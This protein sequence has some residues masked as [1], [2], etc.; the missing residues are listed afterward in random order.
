MPGPVILLPTVQ[1]AANSLVYN[2][3]LHIFKY[4]VERYVGWGSILNSFMLLYI[5]YPQISL[6]F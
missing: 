6:N 5:C 4:N 1:Y 3:T 2:P